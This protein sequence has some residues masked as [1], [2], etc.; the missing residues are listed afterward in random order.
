[1]TGSLGFVTGGVADVASAS[2]RARPLV[3]SHKYA[4]LPHFLFRTLNVIDPG[5]GC[6]ETEAR[7]IAWA[8][9]CRRPHPAAPRSAPQREKGS[10]DFVVYRTAI[11]LL[12]FHLWMCK[13]SS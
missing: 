12:P 7:M 11:Y 6:G 10:G 3:A 4:K 1:M 13:Y 5:Y 8:D 9:P 2:R